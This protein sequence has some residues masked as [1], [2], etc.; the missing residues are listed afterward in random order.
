MTSAAGYLLDTNVLS[1]TRK[2]RPDEQVLKFLQSV[3]HRPVFISVLALGE[4]NK[5]IVKLGDDPRAPALR[6]WLMELETTYE[7]NVLAMDVA[8]TKLWGELS[9]QHS[10]PVIDTMLAA[11]ALHH[12]LVLVTRNISDVAGTGVQPLNPW[13]NVAPIE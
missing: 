13:E 12:R 9:A 8:V 5:G 4:L 2:P 6:H 3:S 7:D 1:E 11:T 10:R